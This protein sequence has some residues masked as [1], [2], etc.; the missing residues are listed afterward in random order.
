[1]IVAFYALVFLYFAGEEYVPSNRPDRLLGEWFLLSL[2]GPLCLMRS[3]PQVLYDGV[4]CEIPP[5]IEALDARTFVFGFV[6]PCVVRSETSRWRLFF[7]VNTKEWSLV[8]DRFVLIES[9]LTF[10]RHVWLDQSRLICWRVKYPFGMFFVPLV[11]F[12][13]N[14]RGWGALTFKL[15]FIILHFPLSILN[16]STNKLK[17]FH[18]I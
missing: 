4:S 9:Y 10:L 2:G 6:V 18:G 16:Y 13:L 17:F 7:L 11:S 12:L 8:K 3:F 15:F 14:C 1:M 5:S